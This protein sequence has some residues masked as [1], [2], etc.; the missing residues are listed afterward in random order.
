[1]LKQMPIALILLGLFVSA[2]GAEAQSPPSADSSADAFQRL[3]KNGDGKITRDELPEAIRRNFDRADADGNGFISREEDAKFRNRTG[4]RRP[5][6]SSRP[7][8]HD[9]IRA[10]RDLPYADTDNPRQR[11]DLYLPKNPTSDEPLPVI[12]WIHGGAWRAGDRRSGQGR[13]AELV[14][15][16]NYAGV[17]IGYRLTGEAIWPAQIHDCKAAVRWI[18]AN[19]KR[20]N[21]DPERIGVWGSSAGGHLVAM[22]G[23]SGRVKP[24]EGTLGKHTDQDSRVTCVVDYFG[25]SD[26]LAM[27][28]YPS[29]MKHDAPDSPESRLVGGPVQ[30]TRE[31][32]RSASPNTYA[33]ADDPPFLIAHGD[34]DFTVPYNQSVRLDEAL[35]KAG[36]DPLFI[37]VE[38]GGH[39]FRAPEMTQRVHQF[40]D[41]HLRDKEVDISEKPI[42]EEVRMRR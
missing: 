30:E 26:L 7:Q 25:P 8:V 39:G 10:E 33:S 42:K 15:G 18:R 5:Q 23:T 31:M 29:H 37:T 17:S 19:A 32:A 34:K 2:S 21:L 27:G 1:M 20:Y 16:G 24:L 38:G 41:K 4:N 40:L 14:A 28:K 22:L 12:A 13:V 35:H 11:L 36:V 3:D 6:T 9:A